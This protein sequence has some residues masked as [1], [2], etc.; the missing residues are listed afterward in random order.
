MLETPKSKFDL[1]KKAKIKDDAPVGHVGEFVAILDHLNETL[2]KIRF[3]DGTWSWY[4]KCHLERFV[5]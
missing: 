2:I 3:I 5:L 1:Y 4:H